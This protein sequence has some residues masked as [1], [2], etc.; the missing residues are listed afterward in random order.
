MFCF[1]YVES[2]LGYWYIT[3][4]VNTKNWEKN[5]KLRK[6]LKKNPFALYLWGWGFH[7]KPPFLNIFSTDPHFDGLNTA[8]TLCV[9]LA[10]WSV[11]VCCLFMRHSKPS[12]E[13]KEWNHKVGGGKYGGG[14]PSAS[15]SELPTYFSFL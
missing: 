3:W 10:Y 6:N 2:D 9:R 7:T 12:F 11:Y 1:P 15:L 14:H 13:L 8:R 4:K 5:L